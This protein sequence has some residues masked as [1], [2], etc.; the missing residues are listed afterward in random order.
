[1]QHVDA[2]SRAPVSNQF[3]ENVDDENFVI[4][5]ISYENEILMHQRSDPGIL[6]K[7]AIL[8][9]NRDHQTKFERAKVEGYRLIQELLYK[10]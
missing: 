10:I 8:E 1:M 5:V 2:L 7:V 6:E 3:G 4:N 9:K